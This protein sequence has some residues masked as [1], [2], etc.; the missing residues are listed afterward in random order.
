MSQVLPDKFN[1]GYQE[2]R[3]YAI[4][5]VNDQR[6]T[7]LA[8]LQA[9]LQKPKGEFHVIDFVPNDA[10][11]RIVIAAGTTERDANRRILERFGISA[12]VQITPKSPAANHDPVGIPSRSRHAASP[13]IGSLVRLLI[14]AGKTAVIMPPWNIVSQRM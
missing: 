2:Y 11:Q 1:I 6:V 4:P 7:S 3:G 5:K 12:A 13:V 10:L 8:D 9:A 14:H